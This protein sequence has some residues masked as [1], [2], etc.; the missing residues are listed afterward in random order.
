MR[1]NDA[2]AIA[3]KTLRYIHDARMK[4][5]APTLARLRELTGNPDARFLAGVI[6]DL[7]RHDYLTGATVGEYYDGVEITIDRADVT[8]EGCAYMNDGSAMVTA[9]RFL[10]VAFEAAL[11]AALSL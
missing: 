10:G 6:G 2:Q 3:Y 5:K 7:L 4:G 9:A 8:I 11:E 1:H